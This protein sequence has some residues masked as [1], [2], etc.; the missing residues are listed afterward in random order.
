M[1]AD[2]YPRPRRRTWAEE[3]GELI[4]APPLSVPAP[5]PAPEPPPRPRRR[6]PKPVPRPEAPARKPPPSRAELA[7]ALAASGL[8]ALG[9]KPLTAC[10]ECEALAPDHLVDCGRVR[11]PDPGKPACSCGY[12]VGSL[13]CCGGAS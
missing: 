2:L 11:V 9:R 7:A 3:M 13:G 10:P 12:P 8:P 1:T 4:A 5:A 6:A